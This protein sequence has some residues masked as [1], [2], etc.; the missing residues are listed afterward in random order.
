MHEI[1]KVENPEYQTMQDIAHDYWDNWLIITNL[2]DTPSG[3]VVR[4]Y[5]YVNNEELTDII[6]EMDKL[7]DV[8]GDCIIRYV[9]PGRGDSLGGLF[10]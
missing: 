7:Y 10:L 5:C 9:G 6:I 1:I 8:Y 4:F 3:G 2:T